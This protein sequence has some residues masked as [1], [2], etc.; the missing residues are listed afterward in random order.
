MIVVDA[1]AIVESVVLE[2]HIPELSDRLTNDG[3]LHAPHLVDV[4]VLHALRRLVASGALSSDRASDARVDAAN[5]LIMRYPHLDLL[6]RAWELRDNLTVYDAVY[7]AL[8]EL[9]DAPLVTC[10]ARL[11]QAPGHDAEI[12]L[13]A[14][15]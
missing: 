1:S 4:E 6:E 11:A 13:F 12:E 2:R 9:L 8:A 3:D 5:L 7:V 10:D 14:P 15:S